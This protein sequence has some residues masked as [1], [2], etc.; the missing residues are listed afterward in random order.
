MLCDDEHELNIHNPSAN[1]SII[2]ITFILFNPVADVANK[3]LSYTYSH[4]IFDKE[5][6]ALILKNLLEVETMRNCHLIGFSEVGFEN[7][8]QYI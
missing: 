1:P 7:L 5:V 3:A 2:D 6:G 4:P 8:I